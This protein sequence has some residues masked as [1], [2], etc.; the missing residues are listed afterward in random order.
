MNV[1]RRM[2]ARC[3][4]PGYISR[5]ACLRFP[6][7]PMLLLCPRATGVLDSSFNT[8]FRMAISM[9]V[10]EYGIT[11]AHRA[12]KTPRSPL[13][14]PAVDRRSEDAMTNYPSVAQSGSLKKVCHRPRKPEA[15]ISSLIETSKPSYVNLEEPIVCH[16]IVARC[17]NLSPGLR[18]NPV[19]SE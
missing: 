6:I 2:S 11:R 12:M 9:I 7:N 1:I 15:G 18:V 10:V 8:S 16:S 13:E 5:R 17:V 4:K 19:T 3:S 14:R